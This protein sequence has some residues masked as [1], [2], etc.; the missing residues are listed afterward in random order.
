MGLLIGFLTVILVLS[1]LFLVFLILLQLPK[2]E[3]GAGVA[4]GGAA[5]DTLFGAGSGNVL[6]KLTKYTTIL[7]LALSLFLSVLQNAY[8]N[9]AGKGFGEK[10]KTKETAAAVPQ[11]ALTP[12]PASTQPAAQGAMALQSGALKSASNA[13]SITATGAVATPKPVSPAPLQ[14]TPPATATPA[15]VAK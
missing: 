13:V 7:F 1:S 6:T 5:A 3:A 2:K 15:P 10:L 11:P 4:F 8:A 12:A 9:R 14:V